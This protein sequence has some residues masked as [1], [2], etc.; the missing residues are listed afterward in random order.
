M[1]WEELGLVGLVVA[2][3][4]GPRWLIP[5]VRPFSCGFCLSVWVAVCLAAT[6]PSLGSLW[7]VGRVA[8]ISGLVAAYTPLFYQPPWTEEAE[9]PEEADAL[10][11]DLPDP[12]PEADEIRPFQ[13]TV[14]VAPPELDR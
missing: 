1:M 3:H 13:Q 6:D 4:A 11:L 7:M 10:Y 14:A 12:L 5:P 9:D 2:Y 8:L